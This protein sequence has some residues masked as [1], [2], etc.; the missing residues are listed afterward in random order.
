ME[1][2]VV[3]KLRKFSTLS[4]QFNFGT[5]IICGGI[6]IFCQPV[7]SQKSYFSASSVTKSHIFLANKLIILITS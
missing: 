2:N 6:Q 3:A 5:F 7:P 1:D 4:F